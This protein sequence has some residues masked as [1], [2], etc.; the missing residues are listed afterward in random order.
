MAR[1]A[2]IR[3]V[4]LLGETSNSYARGLLGGGV[5]Y[6]R[7]HGGG[8]V[9]LGGDRRGG[10]RPPGVLRGGGGGGVGREGGGAVCLGEP[11]GGDQPPPWLSR[12][13]GDGVI[14]RI[15]NARIARAVMR[16]GRPV[17]DVSAARLLPDLPWVETDDEAIARLA[18]E[19]LLER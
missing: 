9:C 1:K 10:R 7:E 16:C 3:R 12:W 6:A 17:V 13:D 15:E 2:R 19:H 4:A 5:D 11:S 14:A 18:A 8:A